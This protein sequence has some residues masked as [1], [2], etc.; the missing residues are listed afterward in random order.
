MTAE[1]NEEEL[2]ER[3]IDAIRAVPYARARLT[4]RQMPLDQRRRIDGIVEAEIGGRPI[5]L[6]VEATR[7]LKA[8]VPLT[9]RFQP[10]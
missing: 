2:L 5:E 8:A 3:L 10:S 9:I 6:I 1:A 4:H 7:H